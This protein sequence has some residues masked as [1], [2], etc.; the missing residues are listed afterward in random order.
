V[1]GALN[2]TIV[3]N[4]SRSVKGSNP[5]TDTVTEWLSFSPADKDSEKW[6]PKRV[7]PAGIVARDRYGS[8]GQPSSATQRRQGCTHWQEFDTSRL[9]D[10][11]EEISTIWPVQPP[12]DHLHL[13]DGIF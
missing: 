3:L 12:D 9:L 6:S 4:F 8:H 5:S 13:R 1:A 10:G 11:L 2:E 7:Y